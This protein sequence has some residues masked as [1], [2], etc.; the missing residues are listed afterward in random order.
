MAKEGLTIKQ[1][2]YAQGL[3]AGLSQREAYKQAFIDSF[4][5]E[6]KTTLPIKPEWV[7]KGLICCYLKAV[8]ESDKEQSAWMILRIKPQYMIPN[9][10]DVIDISELTQFALNKQKKISRY[11][12]YAQERRHDKRNDF[13]LTDEQWIKALE[14]FNEKCAYCESDK[15][16]TYDHLIP[17][18]KQGKFTVDN[19]IPCC[20]KC[21]S[22][23][24]NKDFNEWYAIQTFYSKEKED[25]INDYIKLVKR[26]ER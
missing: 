11:K 1:E 21:N 22:S 3:F 13:S 15:A 24:N 19:I 26:Y 8:N 5:A 18:S 12:R 23:K 16:L 25:K 6:D 14:Y 9:L 4:Y 20:K 17:F 2:K 10:K 7:V